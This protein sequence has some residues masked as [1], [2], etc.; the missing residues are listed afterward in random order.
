MTLHKRDIKTLT[1]RYI[2]ISVADQRLQLIDNKR[3][4]LDAIIATAKN[5]VGEQ[6]G[7]ECTPRGWHKIRAKIGAGCIENTIFVGRRPTGEL[8]SEALQKAHPGRD[9]ILTRILWLSGLQVGFNR[10]GKQDT[11]RRYVYIHG[12]PDNNPMGIPS[13]HGCIKMRNSEVI[14]LFDLIEVGIPVFINEHRESDMSVNELPVDELSE[15]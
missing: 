3:V 4:I 2:H 8:W 9:W 10:L 1:Q 7:S 14:Q 11:M 13:S 6:F 5:G 15:R 12:C